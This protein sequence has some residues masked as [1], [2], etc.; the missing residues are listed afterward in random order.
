MFLSCI[1][2]SRYFWN[3]SVCRTPTNVCACICTRLHFPALFAL[4]IYQSGLA[5]E[6]LSLHHLATAV[7]LSPKQ[8]HTRTKHKDDFPTH[9]KWEERDLI[10][11]C[12]LC[13]P[14]FGGGFTSVQSRILPG[15][16]IKSKYISYVFVQLT[17]GTNCRNTNT[18]SSVSQRPRLNLSWKTKCSGLCPV[19]YSSSSMD[20]LF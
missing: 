16:H 4:I 12:I 14:F 17:H 13:L 8:T 2:F 19:S 9:K 7:S 5:P 11:E 6:M 1:Y 18:K 3:F 15:L 20:I 10:T